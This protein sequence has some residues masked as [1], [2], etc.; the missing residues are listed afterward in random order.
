MVTN[1]GGFQGCTKSTWDRLIL[2][3]KMEAGICSEALRWVAGIESLRSLLP[4]EPE[5]VKTEHCRSLPW[6]R[7][8]P[9]PRGFTKS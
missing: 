7:S 9:V 5:V 6:C 8:D 2:C 1:L 4:S 3:E